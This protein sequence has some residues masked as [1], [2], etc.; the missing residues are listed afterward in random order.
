MPLAPQFIRTVATIYDDECAQKDLLEKAG[1][2]PEY[3]ALTEAQKKQLL[4]DEDIR[5]RINHYL[6]RCDA[7]WDCYWDAVSEAAQE[8]LRNYHL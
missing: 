3:L 5:G 2:L 8:L 7:Y 4:Q 1:K 6:G